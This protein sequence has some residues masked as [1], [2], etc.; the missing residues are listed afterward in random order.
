M[1]VTVTTF[2]YRRDSNVPWFWDSDEGKQSN[3]LNMYNRAF[4]RVKHLCERQSDHEQYSHRH[5]QQWITYADYKQWL[6]HFGDEVQGYDLRRWDYNTNNNITE[7]V[8]I[9]IERN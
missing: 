2:S 9:T 3:E 7:T 6:A 4:M 8:T 5:S 1:P